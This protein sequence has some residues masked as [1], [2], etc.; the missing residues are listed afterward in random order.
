MKSRFFGAGGLLAIFALAAPAFAQ[1][2]AGLQPIKT[3]ELIFGLDIG[4]RPGVSRADWRAFLDAEVTPRFPDGLT[5]YDAAGQWRGS[6]GRLVREPSKVILIILSGVP[7][8][9]A[10]L[11]AIREAYK[12]RFHQDAVALIE[13]SAC[14]GF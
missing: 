5:V 4:A 13:Q 3:A 1:C 12:A 6:T 11:A 8:E 10:K 7:G 9:D 14:A 2:P